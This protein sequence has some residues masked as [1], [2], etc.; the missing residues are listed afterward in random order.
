LSSAS[1][2]VDNTGTSITGPPKLHNGPFAEL[3]LYLPYCGIAAF[4][5][6]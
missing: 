4:S 2:Q 6:L 1:D 5:Y 3:A